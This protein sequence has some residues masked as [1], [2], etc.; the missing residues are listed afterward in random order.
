MPNAKKKPRKA[1]SPDRSWRKLQKNTRRAR[2]PITLAA[3][4]RQGRRWA[5]W[6]GVAVGS[7]AL[8][9]IAVTTF[10]WVR[11]GL[12]MEA[13]PSEPVRE[14]TFTSNGVLD[15]RW[16]VH[17]FRAPYGKPLLAVDIDKLKET[18]EATGQIEQAD[19][20]RVFPDQL[21]ITVTERFPLLRAR[22]QTSQGRVD[23]LLDAH[24]YPYVGS[25]YARDEIDDLP[26]LAGVRLRK[27]NGSYQPI[28]HMGPIAELVRVAR[29]V[30]PAIYDDWRHVSLESYYEGTRD[31]GS[32]IKISGQRVD[33]TIFAP[34]EMTMQMERLARTLDHLRSQGDIRVA[35]IDLT[36]GAQVAVK[37]SN[38]PRGPR[39]RYP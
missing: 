12:Y 6:G 22:V 24:G 7:A 33:E 30:Y 5:L 16:Y 8:L 15:Q 39:A 14:I 1:A 25:G 21:Q 2:R 27:E 31:P 4:F 36:T 32:V 28:P 29:D 19:V 20:Q 38:L 35:R 10:F 34:Y 9:A 17:Q 13:L 37:V 3:L 23:L 18:L 11:E 26:Y